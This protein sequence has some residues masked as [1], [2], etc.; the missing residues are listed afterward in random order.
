MS[1]RKGGVI[2]TGRMY[3]VG[4]APMVDL[5][6][7][8]GVPVPSKSLAGNVSV[9]VSLSDCKNCPDCPGCPD[10]YEDYLS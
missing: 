1:E 7:T 8:N 9:T 5:F 6:P 10:Q 2:N 3:V 4:E